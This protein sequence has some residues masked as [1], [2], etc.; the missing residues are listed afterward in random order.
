MDCSRPGSSIHGISQARILESV[1][2][3]LIY[4]IHSTLYF[5]IPYHWDP[6]PFP[7]PTGNHWFVPCYDFVAISFVVFTC[8]FLHSIYK[9]WKESVKSLSRVQLFATPGTIAHKVPLSMGFSRQE[10]WNGLPFPSSGDLPDP[11]IEPASPALHADSLL[12]EPPGKP[13]ISDNEQYLSFFL[14]LI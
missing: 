1:S 14:W 6:I 8:Y 12:S 2:L 5:L 11:G 7:L 13:N 10:Y 9:W 3:Q 4:F